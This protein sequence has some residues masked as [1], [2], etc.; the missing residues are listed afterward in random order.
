MD[1]MT[2]IALGDHYERFIKKQL[3]TGR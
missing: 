1:A 2:S 3:E